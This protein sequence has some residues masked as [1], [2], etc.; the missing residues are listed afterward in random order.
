MSF[1]FKI[2]RLTERLARSWEEAIK[3]STLKRET[4]PLL[5]AVRRFSDRI[6]RE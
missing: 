2:A 5:L 3:K 1:R 6:W 4:V